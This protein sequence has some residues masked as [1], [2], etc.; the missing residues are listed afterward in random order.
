MIQART[1]TILIM[2]GDLKH[3]FETLLREKRKNPAL[4]NIYSFMDICAALA[5]DG[6]TENRAIFEWCL[7]EFAMM[8]QKPFNIRSV[9]RAVLAPARIL[10]AGPTHR[11][12]QRS[13]ADFLLLLARATG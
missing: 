11:K 9:G 5:N 3:A 12:G 4:L 1:L 13:Q 6:K 8:A 7:T 2:L 10:P